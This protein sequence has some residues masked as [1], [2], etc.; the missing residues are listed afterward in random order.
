MH[1][2]VESLSCTSVHL[3][4]GRGL[5]QVIIQATPGWFQNHRIISFAGTVRASQIFGKQNY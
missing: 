1:L 5:Q 4:V 2:S 3:R